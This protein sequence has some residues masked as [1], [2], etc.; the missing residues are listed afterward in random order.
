MGQFKST[1]TE[2]IGFVNQPK[3]YNI[4]YEQE[5][6][7]FGVFGYWKIRASNEYKILILV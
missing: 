2:D 4:I 1:K 6:F 3:K 7:N 5:T